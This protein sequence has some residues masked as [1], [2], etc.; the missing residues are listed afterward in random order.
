MSEPKADCVGLLRRLGAVIYDSL[1]LLA[2]WLLIG[3][4]FVWVESLLGTA[5]RPL[6]FGVNLVAAWA[7]FTWF[8]VR[9]GQTL[10]MQTWNIILTSVNGLRPTRWQA[11]LRYLIALAQWLLLLLGIHLAREYGPLPTILLTAILIT[12]IGV[13]QMHPQRLMLH[14]W[15]S[16]T[17]LGRIEKGD[18][19]IKKWSVKKGTE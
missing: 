9:S 13:S 15:L 7:F 17:R 12:G 6:Q 10:G 8:W 14:D 18:G 5:L 2:L 19:V 3:L 4:V 16:G 11:T 1:L